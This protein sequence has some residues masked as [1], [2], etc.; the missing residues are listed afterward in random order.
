MVQQIILDNLV[1]RLNQT[2]LFDRL[3]GLTQTVEVEKRYTVEG[4]TKNLQLRV[5]VSIESQ[6][7]GVDCAQ[8]G[9]WSYILPD[10]NMK[11]ICY[12]EQIEPVSYPK[13]A[14]YGNTKIRFFAWLNFNALGAGTQ[15]RKNS[16]YNTIK[17]ALRPMS[18]PDSAI[19]YLDSLNTSTQ[20][21]SFAFFGPEY[22]QLFY[23]PYGFMIVDLSVSFNQPC[24]PDFVP[25]API[26]C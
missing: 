3:A 1:P 12:F 10:S 25:E 14:N 9:E 21:E 20:H 11:G 19:F 6:V 16:V 8:E 23:P 4:D 13:R 22:Q 17:R 26:T 7:T 24:A 5:P 15:E 18:F 2:G